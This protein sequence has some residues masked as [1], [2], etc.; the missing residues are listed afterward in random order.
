MSPKASLPLEIELEG[1][2]E[3][4]AEALR[5]QGELTGSQMEQVWERLVELVSR[6]ARERAPFWEGDLRISIEG[7]VGRDGQDLLGVIFSDEETAPWM[8]RGIDPVWPP[9]EAIQPWAEAHGWAVYNLAWA[10]SVYGI[11][12]KKFMEEALKENEET[13]VGLIGRAIA[14]IM[15]A[16]Y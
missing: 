9:F 14:T 6:E 12:P 3:L 5:I 1:A 8:E 13:I 4:I 16:T 7:E 15:E 2:E 10:L 11:E